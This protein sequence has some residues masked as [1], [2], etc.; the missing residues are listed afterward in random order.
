MQTHVAP[1]DTGT[2]E[3]NKDVVRRFVAEIFVAGRAEA[4]DELVAEDFVA[5]SWP[6]TGDPRADLK[7]A[8]DRVGHGLADPAFTIEDLIAEGDRVAARLT[9]SATHVGEFM[10]LA[11]TGKR[12]T[13]EEIHIFRVRDG[14]AVEHWHQFNPLALMQQL[15]VNPP[16]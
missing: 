4:V 8:I 12:Y 15:G 9:T 13:I 14:Q 7:R 1:A 3:R 2:L 5:H 6:S 11:A 16:S 10:G